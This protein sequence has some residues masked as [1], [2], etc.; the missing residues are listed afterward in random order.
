MTLSF[1]VC[2]LEKLRAVNL[3]PILL[4]FRA[5]DVSS[6]DNEYHTVDDL[7]KAAD[8]RSD[9]KSNVDVSSEIEETLAKIKQQAMQT[10]CK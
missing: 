8:R 5:C 3:F 10:Q 9:G 6:I 7:L 1:S 2:S 4:A